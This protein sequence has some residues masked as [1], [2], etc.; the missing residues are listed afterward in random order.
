MNSENIIGINIANGVSITI[1]GVV[2]LL[3][4]SA[5]SKF[6]MSGMP[7]ASNAPQANYTA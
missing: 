5:V 2:G 7:S 1:M 3:I 4:W 6:A